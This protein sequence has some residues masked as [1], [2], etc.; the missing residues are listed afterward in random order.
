MRH[1]LRRTG[2]ALALALAACAKQSPLPVANFNGI[3]DTDGV[4]QLTVATG[5]QVILD[6]STSTDPS[7]G[8]L[9]FDWT[10]ASLPAGSHAKIESPHNATTRFIADVPTTVTDKYVIQLVVKTQYYLSAPHLLSISALDCGAN[11]PQVN[12]IVPA[13]SSINIGT[14]VLL[15][16]AVDDKDNDAE[17]QAASALNGRKQTEKYAWQLIAVPAGSRA[18][19]RDTAAVLGAFTPDVGGTYTAALTVTDS[20]GRSSDRAHVDVVVAPCG[21]AA[22]AIN[23]VNAPSSAT[24]GVPVQLTADVTDADNT[25]AACGLHQ[26]IA[27]SWTVTGLPR[28]STATLNDPAATNPS[29]TPDL[30]GSYSFRLSVTDSTGL[31]ATAAPVTVL[32]GGHAPLAPV[33][34]FIPASPAIGQAVS[35]KVTPQD[36]TF[37]YRWSVLSMP[38]QS[39]AQIVAPQA[40]VASLVPDASG[41]YLISV[42][43]TDSFGQHAS[44]SAHLT[45]QTC[46][47]HTPTVDGLA[48]TPQAPLIGQG[49]HVT[50]LVNDGDS[51]CAGIDATQTFRWSLVQRP[52]GSAAALVN[53]TARAADFTPDVIGSY[54]LQLVVTDAT[55][56]VSAPATIEV[57]TSTCGNTAPQISSIGASSPSPDPG[58]PFTLFAQVT[59]ADNGA[60]CN[61]G[62]ALKL[63][64][65]VVSRPAGSSATLSDPAAAVPSFAADVPGSYQFS[66]VVTDS[67]GRASMPSFL[68]L[69]TSTCG[70]AIPTVTALPAAVSVQPFQAVSL[71]ATPFSANS[72]CGLNE[73]FTYAWRVASAPS[74]SGATLSNP[75]AAAPTFTPDAAGVYQLAVSVA[76]SH[77]HVSPEAFV[78]VTA[79]ACE[80]LAPVAGVL[81]SS[82]ASP[83]LGAQ[84]TVSA[85]Q[86]HATACFASGAS[87][88]LSYA[89]S[90]SKP[91]NSAAMLDDPGAAAPKFTPDV[92]GAYQAMVTV[93]DGH[94]LASA[95]AVVNLSIAPCGVSNLQWSGT[96]ELTPTLTEPDGSPLSA[97]FAS[98]V[99]SGAFVG[100]SV[101]V[102]AAVTDTPGCGAA[103]PVEPLSYQWALV[104][105]PAGST[106][107]LDSATS[108]SPGFVPD[109]PGDYQVA[110]RVGDA[111]GAVLP[112][113]FA[114]L[115][116]PDCGSNV[117]VVGITAPGSTALSTFEKLTLTVLNGSASDADADSCPAR[118]GAGVLPYSY[119]WT[120]DGGGALTASI[121]TATTFSAGAPGSYT[122]TLVASTANGRRSAPA[123]VTLT[124]GTCGSHAPSIAS[125]TTMSGAASVSRPSVGQAVTVTA[126]AS[127]PDIGVCGDSIAGYEWTLVSAP[128]GSMTATAPGAGASFDLTPDAAGT[129]QYTVVAIDSF[130]LRSAPFPVAI[131]TA[132]CSPAIASVT[133]SNPAPSTNQAIT[134][135]SG[136]PSDACVGAATPSFSYAWQIVSAPP[137]SHALLSSISGKVVSFTA[138]VAGAYQFAV[139]ATDQAG[140]MSAPATVSISA[141]TCG[142]NRPLLGAIAAVDQS[143]GLLPA[144]QFDAG[145]TVKLSSALTDLNTGGCGALT[146]PFTWSWMLL[147]RPAGS[148]ATLSGFDPTPGFVPDVPGAY[149]VSATVTDALGNVSLPVFA[150]LKSSDCGVHPVVASISPSGLVQATV[151]SPVSLSATLSDLDNSACPSRFAVSLTPHWSILTAPAGAHP[152][153]TATQSSPTQL[154]ADVQGTYVIGLTATASNGLASPLATVSVNAGQC[155]GNRPSIV[156][157]TTATSRPPVGTSLTLTA[158]VADDDNG[159][160]C[161]ATLGALQTFTYAWRAV[162]L[163]AG[164]AVDT[165]TAGKNLIFTPGIAGSY[166]FA[167]VAT[168]SA[169]LSSAPFDVSISTA[170][171]GPTLGTVTTSGT[172][173]GLPVNV[174][175]S[176]ATDSCVV[177]PGTLQYFWS[178]SSRPAASSAAFANPA[179][180]S[181]SFVPDAPGTYGVRVTVTDAGGFSSSAETLVTAGG[182]TAGP[183]VSINAPQAFFSGVAQGTVDRGDGIAL[184][185]TV[186]GGGCGAGA[187][188]YTYEWSIFSHPDG[189]TAQLTGAASAT[190]GFTADVANG[191]WQVQLIVR[192][193]LG[194]A[195]TPAVRNVTTSTCGARP[196]VIAGLPASL[197]INTF[198]QQALSVSAPD[199]DLT[200]CPA[201]FSALPISFAWSVVSSP[202]G[203]PAPAFSASGASAQFTPNVPGAYG[204]QVVATGSDGVSSAPSTVAITALQ[205]GYNAPA[206]GALAATQAANFGPGLVAR[207]SITLS[208]ASFTDLDDTCTGANG[209]FPAQTRTLSWTLTSTPPG[210]TAVVSGNQF[211]PD[212]AGSYTAQ[213]FGVDS[214][215][216]SATRSFTFSVG[217]CGTAAPSIGALSASQPLPSGLPT[218][219]GP[220]FALGSPITVDTPTVTDTDASCGFANTFGL[221][222]TMVP[223][224]GS[225]ARLAA[226]NSP[227]PSFT[228]DVTGTYTLVLTA[229]DSTGLSSQASLALDV[230]CGANAPVVSNL[231][232]TQ[233]I[234]SVST[235]V[236]PVSNFKI[237][238]DTSSAANQNANV[239]LYSGV[240]I[241]LSAPFTDAD[242]AC[243]PVSATYAWSLA[244]VP[245]GSAATILNAD[246]ASPTFLPD[247]PGNYGVQVTVTDQSGRSSSTTFAGAVGA[248]GAQAPQAKIAVSSPISL[249]APVSSLNLKTGSSVTLD[250]SSSHDGDFDTLALTSTNVPAGAAGAVSGC[251]LSGALSYHWDVTQAPSGQPFTVAHADQANASFSASS[252]GNYGLQLTVSDG[253]RTD[254]TSFLLHARGIGSTTVVASPANGTIQVGSTTGAN[255]VATVLDTDGNPMAAVPVTLAVTAGFTSNT[256][257]Q[258]SFSTD[259]SGTVSALLTSHKAGN[260]SPAQTKSGETKVVTATSGTTTLG[261][262]SVNFAPGSVNDIFWYVPA[263]DT[264]SGNTIQCPS[265]VPPFTLQ[266][267]EVDG[268]DQ[269]GNVVTAY[270]DPITVAA[271]IAPSNAVLSGTLTQNAGTPFGDLSVNKTGAYVLTASG[272]FPSVTTSFNATPAPPNPPLVTSST[273][274]TPQQVLVKWD[275]SLNNSNKTDGNVTQYHV[276]RATGVVVPPSAAFS[277]IGTVPST[278]GSANAGTGCAN[279]TSCGFLDNSGLA[280]GTQYTYYVEADTASGPTCTTGCSNPSNTTSQFTMPGAASITS[281]QSLSTSSIRVSWTSPTGT[282]S[283]FDV[284]RSTSAG[285]PFNTFAG[286]TGQT[287]PFTD[288]DGTK[289]S[290]SQFFYKIRSNITGAVSP[291]QNPASALS[292]AASGFTLPPKVTGVTANPVTY[293]SVG[294][295]WTAVTG[296]AAV[297]YTVTRIDPTVSDLSIATFAGLATNSLTD[298]SVY[299]SV[300]SYNY[301]V[302]AIN[303]G[304]G[305]VA[306]DN[307]SVPTPAA[308]WIA[309][310]SGLTGGWLNSFAI[311]PFNSAIVY[312]ATGKVGNAASSGGVFQL[313]GATWSPV[314]NG[315]P[316]DVV[317]TGVVATGITSTQLYAATSGAGVFTS[318]DNGLTWN[319]I[320][321]AG[322]S[323][324]NL[325]TLFFDSS[326]ST[327]W[328]GGDSAGGGG[329]FFLGPTD[330]SWT[331]SMATPTQTVQGIVEDPSSGKFW[332]QLG[333]G[334]AVTPAGGLY[335]LSGGVWTN[336]SASLGTLAAPDCS[337]VRSNAS[338]LAIDTFTSP[339]TLYWGSETC[340]LLSRSVSGA[341]FAT[342]AGY[343]APEI[344][345]VVVF[346][347][348]GGPGTNHQPWLWV[349]SAATSATTNG[350]TFIST[351]AGVPTAVRMQDPFPANNWE[352][353]AIAVDSNTCTNASCKLYAGAGDG[354]GAYV[355]INASAQGGGTFTKT[356]TGLTNLNVSLV[357]RDQTA[358]S[359][360]VFAAGD[361]FGVASSTNTGSS[362]TA[363]I[364]A[365]CTGSIAALAYDAGSTK[366]FATCQGVTGVFVGSFTASSNTVTWTSSACTGLSSSSFSSGIFVDTSTSPDTLYF[367]TTG[368]PATIWTTAASGGS[369]AGTCTALTPA[370]PAAVQNV[371]AISVDAN[372]AIYVGSFGATTSSPNFVQTLCTTN[373]CKTA[374]ATWVAPIAGPKGTV[375]F[376][377]DTKPNPDDIYAS[378]QGTGTGG[379]W[380]GSIG[381][382]GT[383]TTIAWTSVPSTPT[384]VTAN[385]TVTAFNGFVTTGNPFL[386]A[387]ISPVIQQYAPV[388]RSTTGAWSA[389]GDGIIGGT[390]NAL[391]IPGGGSI[392]AS[393]VLA[394]T[395]GAG[396][397]KTSTGGQ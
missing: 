352:P 145:D 251:G 66:A 383:A 394:G 297:T 21:G 249:P 155:G 206:I 183:T 62:Q 102:A 372:G 375:R 225:A 223:A 14:P 313:S 44:A 233:T 132:T 365:G 156:S 164:A 216:L 364:P 387:A 26:A 267:P 49:V 260:F 190:P 95:P 303:P 141:G 24:I 193:Q 248:C 5:Q 351:S 45:V 356:N 354:S 203:A 55:G 61:L 220:I 304:G 378:G 32:A 10:F 105:A 151:A 83:T 343:T 86:A 146:Q 42:A 117:P 381:T 149:Q 163:P 31:S 174:S 53:P 139:V 302:Q 38:S 197:S 278:G 168:D 159:A 157:V 28:G 176:S 330:L 285:G 222:W 289:A 299:P 120:V 92:A 191:T 380:S 69:T 331:T 264:P 242:S 334:A 160:A 54:L 88:A 390:V 71:S 152:T 97:S 338:S 150:T 9:T 131:E 181:N 182:C 70:T 177:S 243:A 389:S 202:A 281:V 41:D 40:S 192:D 277:D 116:V 274:T 6:A 348:G 236:G 325:R 48:A 180:S 29:F 335:V 208:A 195:S 59:D 91:S 252:T 370:L 16:P 47:N 235:S 46:G 361:Q 18:Q 327:L 34:Q 229:N 287:S 332:A 33:V 227:N 43:V 51:S 126:V 219:H 265:P 89:W 50:A 273:A 137:A 395:S 8:Q 39:T 245:P 283:S 17:C 128:A 337:L 74:G 333:G 15:T 393:T 13:P 360:N 121:G 292:T 294:L 213:A 239:P 4:G 81:S 20:T 169:G 170:G 320:T 339:A 323:N 392:G 100:T 79:A 263:C 237:V 1:S 336:D 305:G 143:N 199:P 240:P 173:V 256:F 129:Y 196:P 311:D 142:S 52:G 148:S 56:L 234:P 106:A 85:P 276:F 259:V 346:D 295:S 108:A 37:T 11:V 300:N 58:V 179:L 270:Q 63:H 261:A 210:S 316:N 315:I 324:Q 115:H 162:S 368:S 184:S 301:S 78:T 175:L 298:T 231:V 158:N 133:A 123:S 284:L 286:S 306:S 328:A 268:E 186:S 99:W 189:S 154:T 172:S 226:A 269:F 377:I 230:E 349:G 318:L 166:V 241:G 96:P 118:F 218:L 382:I 109:L 359:T 207:A 200:G 35:L 258:T 110:A 3:T 211:F 373:A 12:A 165:S 188:T 57:D 107:R 341:S 386:F 75:A 396:I 244:S 340:G 366:L 388:F 363:T 167:V 204:V 7:G 140:F 326:T 357:I 30:A 355:S 221:S 60:G 288:T 374:G 125:V 2:M 371:T 67:T 385:S 201:R 209:A 19:I 127:D 353:T 23:A 342:Y 262:V 114:T 82:P 65:A 104:S 130:G 124:V 308:P 147:S 205:C 122:V 144:G 391:T 171:C 296:N 247:L 178:I 73:T 379:V 228:P 291:A 68:T 215:G 224:P 290:N 80:A 138:D 350:I 94:G 232:A 25:N 153:L 367:A 321:S 134:L 344:T 322:L 101:S 119:A 271:T 279:F 161:Q 347:Q 307:L 93:R 309:S 22:P 369:I 87:T 136:L 27:Y 358:S 103:V 310:S 266:G 254:S 212:L 198:H 72:G 272:G 314:N 257:S 111:S 255:I 90:L 135:T 319:P 275:G 293:N 238:V 76:D 194:N 64:W 362:W 217:T 376:F 98:G 113:R 36:P 397:F 250:A 317:V 329:I 185:A 84:I 253:S 246:T 112:T 384:L 345:R 77:G 214:T 282:V 312:G 280:D 187:P